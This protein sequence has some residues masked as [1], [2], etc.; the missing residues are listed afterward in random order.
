ML[1]EEQ[2][3]KLG[4]LLLRVFETVGEGWQHQDVEWV[5]DGQDFV[6][7]QAR[8]VT[9]LARR[10]FSSLQNQPDI[11]SNGN[12]RDA[13]PMVLSPLSRHLLID[14]IN[15]IILASFEDTGYQLPIGLQLSRLFKGRLYCIV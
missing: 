11:W 3:R 7:V 2:L 15:E 9:G 1:T 4:H 10:T 5:F 14:I 13:L 12:Y 8:P 6:L